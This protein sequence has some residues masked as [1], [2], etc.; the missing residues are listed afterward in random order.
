MGAS[1]TH[2][3][4]AIYLFCG[5]PGDNGFGKSVSRESGGQIF[6]EGIQPETLEL[7]GTASGDFERD[8]SIRKF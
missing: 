6:P 7:W 1:G 5:I 8:Y 3:D 2:L 4:A